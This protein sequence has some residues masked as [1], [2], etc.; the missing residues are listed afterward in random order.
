VM[1][2]EW[3][4]VGELS[5]LPLPRK[6]SSGGVCGVAWVVEIQFQRMSWDQAKCRYQVG[7]VETK[8]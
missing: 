2:M 1:R 7:K 5:Q 6:I 8:F 3:T 4:R